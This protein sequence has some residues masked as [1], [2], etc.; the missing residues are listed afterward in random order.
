[1]ATGREQFLFDLMIEA[2]E[3]IQGKFLV[4]IKETQVKKKKVLPYEDNCKI[5]LKKFQITEGELLFLK[6][7]GFTL[8]K[9]C[10]KCRENKK[11]FK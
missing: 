6:K 7:K 11:G 10:K 9:R 4:K 3:K 8:P 5:C 2:K 1:M